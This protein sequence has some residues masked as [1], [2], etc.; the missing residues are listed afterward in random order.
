MV[1]CCRSGE[2]TAL[3]YF[4]I[5]EG[6]RGVAV[7]TGYLQAVEILQQDVANALVVALDVRVGS[8]LPETG[9]DAS[10]SGSITQVAIGVGVC[11]REPATGSADRFNFLTVWRQTSPRKGSTCDARRAQLCELCATKVVDP[12]SAETFSSTTC[13]TCN[14]TLLPLDVD[15]QRKV[16]SLVVRSISCVKTLNFCCYIVFVIFVLAVFH[17][18]F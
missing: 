10:T 1:S 5:L 7:A 9:E 18:Q 17:R 16:P 8:A 14:L 3:S 12:W 13:C 6:I 11:S 4:Q 15:V 2:G